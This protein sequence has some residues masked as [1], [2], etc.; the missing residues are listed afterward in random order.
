M[1]GVVVESAVVPRTAKAVVPSVPLQLQY[2]RGMVNLIR[3]M[4]NSYLYW[5]KSK[6]KARRSE[7]MGND[8][9]PTR[10]L[11]RELNALFRQWEK[12]FDEFAKLRA[13]NFIRR[14][15]TNTLNQLKRSLKEAG[16]TVRFRNSRRV[17]SILRAAVT[18]NVGLIKS[19]PS[20]YHTQV[21][22]I[23]MQGIK[24]G[25]DLGYITRGLQREFGVSKRRAITIARDQTN[26]ATQANSVARAEEIGVTHGFWMHRGGGKVPRSTHQQF[27]GERFLLSKGL[28]DRQAERVRGGGY[29]GRF[30]KP[31][32]L[33]NC[34]CTFRIDISTVGAGGSVATDHARGRRVIVLPTAII[35]YNFA[36]AA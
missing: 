13:K 20:E 16:L 14:T 11:E 24:N 2:Q 22:T 29:R 10:A 6:Y 31:A 3:E 32:E 21:N 1:A 8:E 19:I 30:V 17:N 5:I 4:H 7:I 34:H 23:V 36:E 9:S 35:E 28:Y 15:N 27:H 33:I 18:E 12:R 26:K 25:R